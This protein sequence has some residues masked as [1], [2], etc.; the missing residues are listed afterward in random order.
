MKIFFHPMVGFFDQ[1][2][3]SNWERNLAYLTARSKKFCQK[4]EFLDC[5]NVDRCKTHQSFGRF[6]ACICSQVPAVFS[7][8]DLWQGVQQTLETRS[9]NPLSLYLRRMPIPELNSQYKEIRSS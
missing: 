3:S 1:T 9:L 6:D 8:V 2:D 7:F 5:N 4:E